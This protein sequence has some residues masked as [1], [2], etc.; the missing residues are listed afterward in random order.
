MFAYPRSIHHTMSYKFFSLIRLAFYLYSTLIIPSSSP[1]AI[2][3]KSNAWILL[4]GYLL[5]NQKK[6]HCQSVLKNP[7]L[8]FICFYLCALGIFINNLP[9]EESS[10][11]IDLSRDMDI[12]TRGSSQYPLVLHYRFLLTRAIRVEFHTSTGFFG[13]LS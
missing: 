11:W 12:S 13:R 10:V 6:G 7:Y 2:R 8:F 5:S 3:F 9:V 4:I 1:V